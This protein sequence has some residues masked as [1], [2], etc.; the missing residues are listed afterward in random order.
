MPNQLKSEETLFSAGNYNTKFVGWGQF[1]LQR[2]LGMWWFLDKKNLYIN[3][4]QYFVSRILNNF[5]DR[6][7]NP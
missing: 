5:M 7:N 1:E 2:N 3:F 6:L 4:G